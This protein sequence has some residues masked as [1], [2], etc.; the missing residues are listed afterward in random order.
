MRELEASKPQIKK[1][2]AYF[3]QINNRSREGKEEE[4]RLK[5]KAHENL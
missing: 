3:G 5:G 1:I 4:I 2:L